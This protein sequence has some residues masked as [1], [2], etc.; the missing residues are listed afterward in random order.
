MTEEHEQLKTMAEAGKRPDEI[1]S[2]LRRSEAAVRARAWQHG[3]DLRTVTGK[4]S[5]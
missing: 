5:K 1:A 4:R 3:I 2:A